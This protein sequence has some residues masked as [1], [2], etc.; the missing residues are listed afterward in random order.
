M[1]VFHV[2]A[3]S[4]GECVWCKLVHHPL[5]RVQDPPPGM[6]WVSMWV[7][8]W[9][10]GCLRCTLD[11][12]RRGRLCCHWYALQTQGINDSL[13]RSPRGVVTKFLVLGLNTHTNTLP[14]WAC[15]MR[16]RKT[17]EDE[18]QTQTEAGSRTQATTDTGSHR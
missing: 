16:R 15:N 7:S 13:D 6:A 2:L 10:T 12:Q 18:G 17:H 9:V 14:G 11:N 5:G 8:M 3:L 1:Q 4:S